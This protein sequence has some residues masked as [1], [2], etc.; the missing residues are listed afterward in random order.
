MILSIFYS[1]SA[2]KTFDH[3]K[4]FIYF[5]AIYNDSSSVEEFEKN[6]LKELPEFFGDSKKA[7]DIS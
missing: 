1:F 7:I 3:E 2:E 6:C 5:F 4:F